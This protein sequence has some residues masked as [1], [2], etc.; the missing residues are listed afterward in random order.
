MDATPCQCET[1]RGSDDELGL[2]GIVR[3]GTE[4][5]GKLESNRSKEWIAFSPRPRPVLEHGWM[6]IGRHLW[7]TAEGY[8]SSTHL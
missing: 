7:Q 6:R 8:G 3:S 4:D 5:E 2:F 1:S